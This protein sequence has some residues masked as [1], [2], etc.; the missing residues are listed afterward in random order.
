M[1]HQR[2]SWI[3]IAICVAVLACVIMMCIEVADDWRT[4]SDQEKHDIYVCLDSGRSAITTSHGV[5]CE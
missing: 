5:S 2:Y 4:F 3:G 1:A